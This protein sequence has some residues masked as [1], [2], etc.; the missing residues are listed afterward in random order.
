MSKKKTPTKSAAAIIKADATSYQERSD[1][2]KRES[3]SMLM[4]QGITD[5]DGGVAE[6]NEGARSI[7]RGCNKIREAG[8]KFE[9]AEKTGQFEFRNWHTDMESWNLDA[10]R[11]EKIK[12]AQKVFRTMPER[13]DKMDDCTPVMHALF[14]L[15]GLMEKTRRIGGET[16]HEPLNP[17]NAFISTSAT[18]ETW[19][20]KMEPAESPLEIYYSTLKSETLQKI[21][22]ATR[23][24]ADRH[25]IVQRLLKE[26]GDA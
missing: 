2:A 5:L 1:L 11:R 14:E 21:E 26:K 9:E 15:S 16:A 7:I 23:P 25:A 4:T 3:V 18:V 12:A 19:L 13:A 22:L 24:M 8:R 20:K 17:F 10:I 6:I